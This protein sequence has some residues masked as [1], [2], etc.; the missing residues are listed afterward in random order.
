MACDPDEKTASFLIFSAI[1]K[2]HTEKF[3]EANIDL[4]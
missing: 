2:T 4:V 3:G 1:R